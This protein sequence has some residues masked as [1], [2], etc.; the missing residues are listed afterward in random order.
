[1]LR[2][3]IESIAGWDK[4]GTCI[5]VGRQSYRP[6]V[7]WGELWMVDGIKKLSAQF[8]FL[9]FGYW[10]PLDDGH[11]E[12]VKFLLTTIELDIDIS[13]DNEYAFR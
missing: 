4:E 12:I 9:D 5:R 13:A 3:F 8:Q 6:N 2:K 11:I 7:A 10:E 1:M